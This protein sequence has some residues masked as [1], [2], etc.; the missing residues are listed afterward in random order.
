MWLPLNLGADAVAAGRKHAVDIG[1]SNDAATAPQP[2]PSAVLDL[3][4]L[5]V[6]SKAVRKTENDAILSALHG[7]RI[8]HGRVRPGRCPRDLA[9]LDNEVTTVSANRKSPVAWKS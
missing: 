5:A 2:Q 3:G 6:E 9:G 1:G 7:D 8:V 4:R